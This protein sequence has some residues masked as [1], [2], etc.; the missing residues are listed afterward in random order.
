MLLVLP[1][2]APVV[3]LRLQI[4]PELGQPPFR[5]L[6]VVILGS[7]VNGVV[8][9]VDI[10]IPKTAIRLYVSVRRIYGAYENEDGEVQYGELAN[11]TSP[12]S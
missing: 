11:R 4:G 1:E 10:L 12:S 9:E 6:S 2:L 7:L 5:H 8:G 3:P